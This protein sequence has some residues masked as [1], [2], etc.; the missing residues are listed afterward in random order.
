MASMRRFSL[1]GSGKRAHVQ[2]L[3]KELTALQAAL[4]ACKG[5]AQRCG[6]ARRALTAGLAFAM[7]VLGFVLGTYR[8][9]LQ[10]ALANLGPRAVIARS[11]PDVDSAYTAYRGSD[12]A[13][14][15]KLARPLAEQGDARAQTLVGLLYSNSSNGRSIARDNL[16]AAKWFRLAA[17]QGDASGQFNLGAMYAEGHGVAQDFAEAV[18]WYQLAADQGYPQAQ[19]N[20]GLWY[21]TDEGGLGGLDRVSAYKWL[22]LA[23]A[24]FAAD[25][26][27]RGR[28]AAVQNRDLVASKMTPEELAEAQRQAREW[29]PKERVASRE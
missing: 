9:P 13:G 26:N 8:E 11:V 1:F 6:R 22:N 25:D 14:A 10:Q 24:R 19:Y 12:Y 5:M 15:L 3:E 16:E 17:E 20:L 29:R 18:R 21:A 2:D 23:A 4:S 7:L 27:P 28:N